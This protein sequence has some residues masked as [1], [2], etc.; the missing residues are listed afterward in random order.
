MI[1]INKPAGAIYAQA[2]LDRLIALRRSVFSLGSLVGVIAV[3]TPISP[4]W[5]LKIKE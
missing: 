3:G 4:S 1:S 5:I 2:V